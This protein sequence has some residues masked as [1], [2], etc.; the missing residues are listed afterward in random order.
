MDVIQ[1]LKAWPKIDRHVVLTIGN[2]DGVHR[3]H[4][5]ILQ[6]M[7]ELAGPNA[8]SVVLTF[9]NHPSEVLRPD[10]AIKRLSTVSHRIQLFEKLEI[11][12]LC[13][14]PFTLELA[15]LSAEQ[16]LSQLC[17]LMT[18]KHLVLGHDA[19]LGRGRE[20]NRERVQRCAASLNFHAEYVEPF[21]VD[22]EIV[23][24]SK[25]RLKL[26]EGDFDAVERYL[27]R[28]YS[29][30]VSVVG[31]HSFGNE[32]GFP[33]LKFDVSSLCLPPFG[34]YAVSLIINGFNYRGVANLGIAPNSSASTVPSLEVYLLDRLEDSPT[35]AE[36]VF[37]RFLQP[38]MRFD[39][40]SFG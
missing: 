40:A 3:G 25:I 27:G 14:L 37:H 7:K 24:S 8:L 17:Q 38:E 29:I 35:E 33:T 19:T 16:F 18:I 31:G 32:L 9:T 26:Q 20:G 23:S 39:M 15:S 30:L 36:I 11:D 34:V 22:Q 10:V 4:Q 2:F 13:L 5:A 21:Y 6:R 1:D 12:R 28:R